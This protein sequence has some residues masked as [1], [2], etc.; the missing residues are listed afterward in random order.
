[1]S[2][3]FV[4]PAKRG[5]GHLAPWFPGF[6]DVPAWLDDLLH[7][8][9]ISDGGSHGSYEDPFYR[10]LDIG[11]RIPFSTATDWFVDDFSRVYVPLEAD[12]SPRDWLRQLAAGRSSIANG[13]FR[14][15][16]VGPWAAGDVSEL[17]E[18][19]KLTIRGRVVGRNDCRTAEL[20]V[21]GHVVHAVASQPR[22]GCHACELEFAATVDAQAWIAVRIP[23][24]GVKNELDRELFAH[25]SPID[26]R[27]ARRDAFRPA[28]ARARL[29][30]KEKNLPL[31]QAQAT[32]ADG[33]EEHAILEV[34]RRAIDRLKRRLADHAHGVGSPP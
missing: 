21:N 17:A 5:D 2:G 1:L 30:A 15:L 22:E 3:A 14:K 24:G 16:D 32:F 8:R 12:G 10:Y 31:I 23:R 11:L 7:A 26:V 4:G 18:P 13:T 9:N 25:A 29:S 34:R 33:A 20:V 19:G 28:A 6:E 27:L